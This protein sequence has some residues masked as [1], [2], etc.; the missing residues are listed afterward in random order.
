MLPLACMVLSGALTSVVESSDILRSRGS[1][2]DKTVRGHC[3]ERI[4]K[5]RR[6]SG[7][8]LVGTL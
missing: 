5:V 4:W 2:V 7:T 3:D 1:S 8:I 6:T